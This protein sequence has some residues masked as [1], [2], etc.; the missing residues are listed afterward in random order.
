MKISM[1]VMATI[2]FIQKSIAQNVGYKQQVAEDVKGLEFIKLL[3]PVTYI[4]DVPSLDKYLNINYTEKEGYARDG[5]AHATTHR[6]SGFIAQEVEQAAN[7]TGFTFS[8]VDKPGNDKALYGLRYGDF[9]VPLV[10]AVQEQ[11]EVIEQLKTN[12][13]KFKMQN[14]ELNARLQKLEVLLHK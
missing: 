8:G 1:I 13:A 5:Y 14:E 2:F 3:R 11:Q 10:K 9:V 6:E 4:V 12:N 7:K